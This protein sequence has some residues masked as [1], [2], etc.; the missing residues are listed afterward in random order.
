VTLSRVY[1]QAGR[2]RDA[3]QVLELLLQR[4]PKNAAALETLQK[5]RSG[6]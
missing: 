5:L 2:R 4:N 3:V 1:L 6:G